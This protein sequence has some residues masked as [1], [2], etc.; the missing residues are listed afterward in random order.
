MGIYGLTYSLY[1]PEGVTLYW[2]V[3][4]AENSVRKRFE[5]TT[6]IVNDVLQYD[7]VQGKCQNL[8]AQGTVNI[9][10]IHSQR[11]K[12]SQQ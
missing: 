11:D 2:N 3:K 7:I 8:N 4:T 5:K 12:H 1:H 10:K 6:I 9:P